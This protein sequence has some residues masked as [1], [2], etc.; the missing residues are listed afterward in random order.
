MG[1]QPVGYYSRRAYGSFDNS[2]NGSDDG[3]E[4][5]NS[6][7]GKMPY[8]AYGRAPGSIRS[9]VSVPAKPR[10]YFSHAGRVTVDPNDPLPTPTESTKTKPATEPVST[11]AKVAEKEEKK[12]S[13]FGLRF[14]KK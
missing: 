4:T 14:G 12:K 13:K 6:D 3:T 11:P 8:I 10:T 2:P 5:S 7:E 9:S 1:K